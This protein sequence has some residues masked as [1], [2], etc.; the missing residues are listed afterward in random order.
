MKS[1]A[2]TLLELVI[3]LAIAG[4]LT[5]FAVPTYRSQVA[6]A[7]RVD[8]ASALYRAAQFIEAG[9]PGDTGQ[10]PSALP[11]GLDQAPAF[12]TAV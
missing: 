12:G 7:H 10:S 4:I 9:T 8:A 11:A 5:V 3:A 6:R 2:F 1:S